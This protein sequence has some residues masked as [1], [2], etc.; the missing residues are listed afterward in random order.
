MIQNFLL[1]DLGSF[2][3]SPCKIHS[4]T[5]VL[6]DLY[7]V[8]V[9]FSDSLRALRSPAL[10]ATE[11][12]TE[13]PGDAREVHRVVEGVVR[14]RRGCL[15]VARCPLVSQQVRQ[16]LR[17]RGHRFRQMGSKDH[18]QGADVPRDVRCVLEHLHEAF[19]ALQ[20]A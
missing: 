18:L 13:A 7:Q 19:A 11:E 9:N 17:F 16:G 8:R 5:N 4:S 10:Y 6:D 1:S 15:A 12:E 3:G 14:P 20:L 2:Q